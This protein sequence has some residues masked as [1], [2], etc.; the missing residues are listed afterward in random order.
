M[1]YEIATTTKTYGDKGH[2]VGI[3]LALTWDDSP[4]PAHA[5]IIVDIWQGIH[6]LPGGGSN[7]TSV[8]DGR[9]SNL[10]CEDGDWEASSQVCGLA[11]LIQGF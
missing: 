10:T 6:D 3:D 9:G 2:T 8:S 4:H 1:T 11:A 5:Y 7:S